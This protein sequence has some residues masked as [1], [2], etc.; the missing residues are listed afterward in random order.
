MEPGIFSHLSTLIQQGLESYGELVVMVSVF[1][2]GENA[3][4]SVFALSA[5]Q[6]IDPVT[7]LIYAFLGSLAS[8]VFWFFVTEYI[9]RERYEKKFLEASKEKENKFFMKLIDKH[10]FWTLIFIKFLVGMR[11]IL[12][13]YIVIKNRIPFLQK[14]LL[15]SIGTILF[16]AI[17]FPVGWYLGKGFSHALTIEQTIIHGVSFIVAVVLIT[18][19]AP[20]MLKKVLAKR[21]QEEE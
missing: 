4:I 16:M 13:I 21:Y 1:L 9:L 20:R 19:I 2:L 5:N 7:A 11:L 8:D 14:V 15:D 6:Y 3:A 17:L 10:F 18:H 12:T